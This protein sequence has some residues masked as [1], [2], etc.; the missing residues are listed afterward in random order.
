MP[1]LGSTSTIYTW[2]LTYAHPN[3]HT[4]TQTG[5]GREERMEDGHI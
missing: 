1:T 4:H 2:Y 5:G 3:T